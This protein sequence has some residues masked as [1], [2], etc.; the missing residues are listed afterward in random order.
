MASRQTIGS[1]IKQLLLVT[2]LGLPLLTPLARW[3]AVP[4]THD[5]H[6]HVHR[7]AAMRHAW[8][9]GTFF[10][11][12]LPDLAFGYGYPFFVYREPAPLYAVLGPHLLGLPMAAASN[13]F[14]ALTI[15]A[16]G[17]FMFL[18]VRDVAGPRAGLV[19]AVA[20][21][22][23]PYVLLDALVRGNAPESLALPLF[24]LLLLWTG[25][26]GCCTAVAG[27][28]SSVWSGLALLSF[29]H[30]IS[31]LIFTPTLLVYLL[32]VGWSARP[33][34][35]TLLLRLALLFGLGLGTDLLLHRRGDPGD[36]SGHA[37]P[38]HDHAQQ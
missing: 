28:S 2:L 3:G 13:L 33:G 16:A 12:W 29:S 23:A 30:N 20:Y 7:V 15:L 31:T 26:A 24:P 10:T 14:Y 35:R 37:Q 19:S 32:A 6:L 17:W 22:A 34:W 11:R 36:G 5:G 27:P 8:E 38:V 4:C 9:D 21:M 1:T 18:W 25:G